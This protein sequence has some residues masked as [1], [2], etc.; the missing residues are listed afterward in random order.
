M[1]E[2][3]ALEELHPM[4]RTHAVAMAFFE[5]HCMNEEPDMECSSTVA[6]LVVCK[7]VFYESSIQKP[8]KTLV[9]CNSGLLCSS[10][11]PWSQKVS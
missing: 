11:R 6:S 10:F 8:K 4:E 7:Q 1:P 2:Q 5:C 9:K 3:P